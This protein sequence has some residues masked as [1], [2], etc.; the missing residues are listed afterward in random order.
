MPD[1][2]WERL[3]RIVRDVHEREPEARNRYLVE[4]CSDE[5]QLLAEAR[6]LLAETCSLRQEPVF[7]AGTALAPEP[8]LQLPVGKVLAGRFRIAR[9]IARGGMGEVYE[10]DDLELGMRI[11]LKTIRREIADNPNSLALF[12][13][14]TQLARRVTHPNV[15]RIFDLARHAETGPDGQE[16]VSTF[17]TMELL[18]GETLGKHLSARGPFKPEQALPLIDQ[19]ASALAAAHRAGVIHQDLKPGNVIL[20]SD[21]AGRFR[22]VITDFGLAI[23]RERPASRKDWPAGGTPH[24]MAPEQVEG[25][26]VTPASD[27][28]AFALVIADMVGGS[29][30]RMPGAPRIEIPLPAQC[31][32]WKPVLEACLERDPA[33]RPTSPLEVARALARPEPAIRAGR[34]R[35]PFAALVVLGGLLLYALL[36]SDR[37]DLSLLWPWGG[38]L[39]PL[40]IQMR[41]ITAD[42]GVA[43]YPALS[44]DGGW[45]VYSSDGGSP[46]NLTLWRRPVQGGRAVRLTGGDADAV[47]PTISPDGRWVAFK[48]G[49]VRAEGIFLIPSSGGS[50]RLLAPRG[51]DPKFSPDGKRLAYWE[52]DPH[53]GFGRAYVILTD[54]GH[55]PDPIAREFPDAHNPVW[56]PDGEALLV[57]G[58]RRSGIPD[59]EHDFWIVNVEGQPKP[60]EWRHGPAG[61]RGDQ[62]ARACVGWNLVPMVPTRPAFFGCG[63]GQNR[64]MA[65]R[66]LEP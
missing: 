22:A 63:P 35:W 8:H 16:Q 31:S 39:A 1:E 20:A 40:D 48:S 33:R 62:P 28:Y 51:R 38:G 9:F 54:P 58:T 32:G 21:E 26:G 52:Q 24:Y 50:K 37:W 15:C 55:E 65:P 3:K 47:S 29:P 2:R 25:N 57:C 12:K 11:A 41:P 27:I 66:A 53:T 17:L 4:G 13:Q 61:S 56:T 7:E 10:A 45:I 6:L 5:P 43:A 18:E 64:P 30:E 23:P 36:A 59:Q 14:E 46:S 44:P 34:W 60:E 19:M 49:G 42:A